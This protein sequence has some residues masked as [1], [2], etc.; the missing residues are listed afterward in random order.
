MY[1]K[2]IYFIRDSHNIVKQRW[3]IVPYLIFTK[4]SNRGF[5]V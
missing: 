2:I 3:H 5:L 1:T 4:Q